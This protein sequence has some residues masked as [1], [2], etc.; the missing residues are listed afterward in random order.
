[1]PSNIKSNDEKCSICVKLKTV[2]KPFHKVE[3]NSSPSELIYSD[4]E[5]EGILNRDSNHY[6]IT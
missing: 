4:V 1:M 6:F 3:R 2:R 5:L